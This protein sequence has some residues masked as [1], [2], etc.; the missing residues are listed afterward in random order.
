[1][2]YAGRLIHTLSVIRQTDT[3]DLDDYGQPITTPTT[4]TVNG[5]P[6]PKRI[7]EVTAI[8]QSG[9][10]IGTWTIFLAMDDVI[11]A[12]TITHTAATCA[13]PEGV[14]LPDLYWNVTGSRNPAGIGH[15][16]EVDATAVEGVALA[17]AGS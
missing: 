7:R 13:V 15:H 4:R 2:S 9:A 11:E 6:Q 17:A 14:D 8:H 1:V 16:L 3:G 10:A 5:L 12:D